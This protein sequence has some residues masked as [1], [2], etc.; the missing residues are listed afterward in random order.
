MATVKAYQQLDVWKNAMTLVERTYEITRGFPEDE[1]YGLTSQLRRAAVSIALNI[2]E[3][4]C[5]RTTA[6][7]IN[8]VSIALGS[9]AEVETC[10]EIGRRLGFTGAGRIAEVTPVLESTGKLLNGLLRSL[11]RRLHPLATSH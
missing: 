9:H 8:H 5:R 10:I 3:G 2:A 6:A 11:E 7:Y 1:R 4:A